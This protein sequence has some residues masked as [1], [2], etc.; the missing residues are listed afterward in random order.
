M[1]VVREFVEDREVVASVR[2]GRRDDEAWR[3]GTGLV[4]AVGGASAVDDGAVG[5][6]NE[7]DV[8]VVPRVDL[9]LGVHAKAFQRPGAAVIKSCREIPDRVDGTVTCH[10]QG[11]GSGGESRWA[12]R[13]HRA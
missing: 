2:A 5:R 10:P 6:E 12:C 3:S 1:E 11:G 9:G 4:H 13:R 8:E 7:M